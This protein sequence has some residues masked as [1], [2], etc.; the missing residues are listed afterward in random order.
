MKIVFINLSRENQ[1]ICLD[2]FWESFEN[3]KLF[4]GILFLCTIFYKLHTMPFTFGYH[5]AALSLRYL[6]FERSQ[7]QNSCS[8]PK[9]EWHSI[10]QSTISSW[11]L[12]DILKKLVECG[13]G[14]LHARVP[15][16]AE[17]RVWR[18]FLTDLAL[19]DQ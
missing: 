10:S 4:N 1:A 18:I 5:T 14:K 2:L 16:F 19:K 12:F 7:R 17:I 11:N 3:V 13:T 15:Q 6:S 9:C 8:I